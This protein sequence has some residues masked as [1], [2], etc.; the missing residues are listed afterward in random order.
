M[1]IRTFGPVSM[2]LL[3]AALAVSSAGA[4]GGST[5]NGPPPPLPKE[6]VHPSGAFS[7]R[8]PEGW[9]AGLSP[10]N[11]KA[12]QADGDGLLVRF[13]FEPSEVGFDALHALCMLERLAG[14]DDTNP[15]VEYEYDFLSGVVNGR[16][17]LDSAFIVKYDAKILGSQEWRQRNVTVVGKGQSLCVITY[18]PARVWKKSKATRALLDGI[19]DSVVFR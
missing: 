15:Q 11:P 5:K 1:T 3:M 9:A 7:F 6:V 18:A 12:F 19:V 13:L 17:V 4:P 10:S 2:A 8:T 14:E 16:K